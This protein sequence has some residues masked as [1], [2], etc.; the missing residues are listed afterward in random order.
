MADIGA[1]IFAPLANPHIGTT[2]S[3]LA[4]G[5]LRHAPVLCSMQHEMY[6]SAIADRN[7][8]SKWTSRGLF[9]LCIPEHAA[10]VKAIDTS[11]KVFR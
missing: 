5:M 4:V 3:V 2:P 10:D 1:P 7:G 6:P 9:Y 11:K 8:Y